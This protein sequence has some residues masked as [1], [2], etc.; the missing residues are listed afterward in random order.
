MHDAPA[1]AAT[2]KGQDR[3]ILIVDDDLEGRSSLAMLLELDGFKVACAADGA[4]A[5]AQAA[6]FLPALVILDLGLPDMSGEEVARRLRL[7]GAPVRIVV[8]SGTGPAACDASL[9]DAWVTKPAR[10]EELLAGL[11]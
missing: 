1:A 9:F 5:L 4:Q 7:R 3:R 8:L 11:G 2:D 10:V 6:E